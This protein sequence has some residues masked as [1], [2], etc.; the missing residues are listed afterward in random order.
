VELGIGTTAS[1]T[2]SLSLSFAPPADGVVCLIL[3]QVRKTRS[4]TGADKAAK[5]CLAAGKHAM[6]IEFLLLVRPSSPPR[7]CA[8]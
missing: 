7:Q 6:A 2:L 1:L 3:T 8:T 5:H 4:A